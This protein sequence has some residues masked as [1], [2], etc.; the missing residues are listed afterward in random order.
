MQAAM[1]LEDE[2]T[3]TFLASVIAAKLARSLRRRE[4]AITS[5]A[6]P[7]RLESPCACQ[8]CPVVKEGGFCSA[9]CIDKGVAPHLSLIHI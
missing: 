6:P 7:P 4:A 2:D 8:D 5:K 9:M 1:F 3:E